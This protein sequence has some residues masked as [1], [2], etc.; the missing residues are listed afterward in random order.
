M[1]EANKTFTQQ[2]LDA[3]IGE[4]LSREREKYADYDSLKDKAAKFDQLE[5]ASKSELQKAQEQAA[6]FKATAENLKNEIA[7]R[8]AREKIATEKGVP[9]YLLTGATEEE[10]TKQA[11]ALLEWGGKQKKYPNV[12]DS[13]EVH[14]SNVKTRDQFADWF[15]NSLK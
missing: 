10:C 13:G 7:T 8:N 3:I 12:K 11:E 4:R 5:E 14:G 2:E 6:E 1:D 15:N 9:A